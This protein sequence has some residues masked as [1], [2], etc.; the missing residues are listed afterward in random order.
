MGA[1]TT[2]CLGHQPASGGDQQPDY[3]SNEGN[4]SPNSTSVFLFFVAD[5]YPRFANALAKQYLD[6]GFTSKMKRTRRRSPTPRKCLV[7]A[8]YTANFPRDHDGWGQGTGN[9][10]RLVSGEV[11]CMHPP[12]GVRVTSTLPSL[13][14]GGRAGIGHPPLPMLIMF[15][16][17]AECL[18]SMF[19]FGWVAYGLSR[20]MHGLGMIMYGLC[21]NSS[22]R[23]H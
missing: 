22:L 4:S 6:N 21:I 3:Y 2:G 8:H 20:M 14:P 23:T 15:V 7:D 19:G 13:G 1:S 17:S 12:W 5:L 9:G 16:I 10:G 18:S 11:A